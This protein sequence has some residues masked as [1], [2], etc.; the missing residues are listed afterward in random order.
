[1]RNLMAFVALLFA[2]HGA[3]AVSAPSAVP[4]VQPRPG[5]E[6]VT[7]VRY[8]DGQE[9]LRYTVPATEFY[10]GP[11]PTAPPSR[12]SK[13]FGA[14]DD[15]GRV[16]TPSEPPTDA[17]TQPGDEVTTVR[18]RDVP[19]DGRWRRTT[20]YRYEC[21]AFQACDWTRI[22]NDITRI[23]NALQLP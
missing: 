13:D 19:A 2:L 8:R 18:E 22:R 16:P 14:N 23:S 6:T 1:M 15:E 21:S 4:G 7:F 3:T 11:T 20:T 17:E 5:V 12:L 9:V 10:G